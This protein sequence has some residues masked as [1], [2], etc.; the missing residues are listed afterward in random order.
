[1]ASDLPQWVVGDPDRLGQVLINLVGNAVKFT[2]RGT[3]EV[4]VTMVKK[5]LSF[6]VSDTGIGIP[7][8]K[9]K[10][11]FHSF[12]QLDSSD[13][14]KFGGTGL[15]LA[16]SKGLV[17]LMG[18][19]ITVRG[20]PGGGSVFS[21]TLPL[22]PA[23]EQPRIEEAPPAPVIEPQPSAIRILL[24][25]DDPHILS[26]LQTSLHRPDWHI[27]EAHNGNEAIRKWQQGGVGLILMDV[28]MPVLDGMQATRH[29][30]TLERQQ[31]GYTY[32]VGITA[33]ARQQTEELC[34]AAGMDQVL[35]KPLRIRD[36]L[37][38]IETLLAHRPA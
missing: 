21:F 2:D 28:Q 32:I 24:A 26:L 9:M 29:I 20:R 15:G 16:I 17:E 5:Q 7:E 25:E 37:H 1:M 12:S 27:E 18:G 3:V 10:M 19:E 6:S 4:T 23:P 35:Q 33:D 8:E 22:Q 30:R 38:V 11:L 13:T 31:G 36:L 14:R 34:L